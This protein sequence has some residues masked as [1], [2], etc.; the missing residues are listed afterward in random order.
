MFEIVSLFVLLC[1]V[2]LFGCVFIGCY[3]R[4]MPVGFLICF[5][6]V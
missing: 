1:F 4:G 6:E 5:V 3:K 2:S